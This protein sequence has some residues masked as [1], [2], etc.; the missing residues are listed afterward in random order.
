MASV[1]GCKFCQ[2]A[3]KATPAAIVFEDSLSLAFLDYRPVFPGH[4]LLIPKDHYAT[5]ADLPAELIQP[6]ITLVTSG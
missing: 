2:I 6:F 3:T 1:P 5:L 4:T